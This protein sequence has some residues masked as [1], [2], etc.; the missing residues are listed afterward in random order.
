MS[1]PIGFPVASVDPSN[2]LNPLAATCGKSIIFKAIRSW[3]FRWSWASLVSDSC[4]LLALAERLLVDLDL[5]ALTDLTYQWIEGVRYSYS[6]RWSGNL[7]LAMP[8]NVDSQETSCSF[9]SV[10]S[11]QS[12][13][14]VARSINSC[15]ECCCPR[16]NDPNIACKK[17]LWLRGLT[18]EK[19]SSKFTFSCFACNSSSRKRATSSLGCV[20]SSDL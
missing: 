5:G 15:P 2:A 16:E 17:P 14:D 10:E 9:V 11:S 12:I 7:S 6:S 20:S 3:I 8:C 19:C 1:S 18:F 4:F 13:T